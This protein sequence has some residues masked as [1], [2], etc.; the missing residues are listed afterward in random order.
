MEAIIVI[1]IAIP[2][3]VVTALL[4]ALWAMSKREAKWWK[5][6]N[7][8]I[9][10]ER[11]R[12]EEDKRKAEEAERH[13]DD[14]IKRALAAY[15]GHWATDNFASRGAWRDLF[16]LMDQ[17]PEARAQLEE[18]IT[19]LG[20]PDVVIECEPPIRSFSLWRTDRVRQL[21]K[22]DARLR[23]MRHRQAVVNRMIRRGD[24]REKALQARLAKQ[25]RIRSD[26]LPA[27]P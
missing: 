24:R 3:A 12:A 26:Q 21:E 20:P 2:F 17:K 4:W 11:Q 22:E 23:D 27:L 14:L 1:C 25:V 16:A 19:A 13:R 10:E 6:E 18:L 15:P 9:E 5:E 7:R 8:F